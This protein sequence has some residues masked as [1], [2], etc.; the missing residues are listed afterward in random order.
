V[1]SLACCDF[2]KLKVIY[3]KVSFSNSQETAEISFSN[4][5]E[6]AETHLNAQN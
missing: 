5:R 2:T 4:S 6:A 3:T 1:I